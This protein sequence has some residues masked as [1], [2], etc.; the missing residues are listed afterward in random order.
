MKGSWLSILAGVLCALTLAAI[1]AGY[2]YAGS[3]GSAQLEALGAVALQLLFGA[4]ALVALAA[5]ESWKQEQPRFADGGW[6]TLRS[7]AV[8]GPLAVMTQ[9]GLGAG[10]RYQLI[11]VIPHAV[12]AFA[13]A[14]LLLMMGT[15]VL[16]QS[17]ASRTMKTV[18]TVLLSL[19]CLQVVLGVGALLARVSDIQRAAWMPVVTGLH[20]GTGS[21]ILACTL[22]LSAFVLRCAEPAQQGQEMVSTGRH[23]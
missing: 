11:S 12:W 20:L 3:L 7:L 15:Y 22:I 13:A 19:T 1:A 2:P 23:S 14:V 8:I 6:P 21:L 17:Q 5:S 10:Y 16:T 4:L 18:A 9:I